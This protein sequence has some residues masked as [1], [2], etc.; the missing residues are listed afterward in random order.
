[1]DLE[2]RKRNAQYFPS[3]EWGQITMHTALHNTKHTS[4]QYYEGQ[5]D[6]AR[7]LSV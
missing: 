2:Q 6:E 5:T 1:M 3:Q 4:N 7:S